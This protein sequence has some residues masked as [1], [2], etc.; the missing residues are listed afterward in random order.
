MGV[1]KFRVWDEDAQEMVYEVGLT[2][3]GIPYSIPNYAEA[4][5]QF[6]YYPSYDKMQFTGLKDKNGIEIYEW[7]VL[8]VISAYYGHEIIATVKYEN[9]L[10]SFVFETGEDQGYSRIDASFKE[11]EV[12]GNIY[13]DPSRLE[14]A[15]L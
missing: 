1:T 3:E 14:G 5:D 2:P 15:E 7:D 6:D 10:A 8:K 11:V 13:E 12:V 4:S 9:S